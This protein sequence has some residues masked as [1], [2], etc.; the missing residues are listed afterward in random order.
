MYEMFENVD[1][2]MGW[3]LNPVDAGAAAYAADAASHAGDLKMKIHKY[4]LE[5]SKWVE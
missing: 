1:G 2:A 5:E 3:L 4:I